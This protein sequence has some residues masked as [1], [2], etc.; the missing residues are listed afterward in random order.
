[1][2]CPSNAQIRR[3]AKEWYED[4]IEDYYDARD[5]QFDIE[6]TEF[7]KE[8]DEIELFTEDLIQ[9]FI[10]NFNFPDQDEWLSNEYESFLGDLE[11]TAY[12]EWKERE[13]E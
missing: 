2:R 13:I 6:F 1:M 5:D 3:N 11:D 7:L 10:D 8:R 9:G 12:Q 4:H